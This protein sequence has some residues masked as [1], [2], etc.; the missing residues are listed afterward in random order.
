MTL[1]LSSRA[2]SEINQLI[3]NALQED[4]GRGNS[5]GD[6]TSLACIPRDTL[7]KA[8]LIIKDQGVLAGIEVAKLV[9]KSVDPTL[10][11]EILLE[12]GALVKSGDIALIVMGSAHSIL[13]AERLVLNIMQRMSGIATV[14]HQVV[15]S[16][17]GTSTRV[18][19]T[20]K[21]TPNCRILEKMAVQIGG[22]V[23]HRIGLYDMI[24]IKDNHVDYAGGIQNALLNTQQYLQDH[25][26]PLAIE[27][28][29][30]NLNELQ[31]VLDVSVRH[32]IALK[33]IM[34]DNFNLPTLKQAV[35]LIDKRYETEGSGGITFDNARDYACCG[36]DFISMGA[37]TH[38]VRSL[39]MSLK[40][41]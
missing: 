3:E 15:S 9:F 30:R 33:R 38:S 11:L 7:Q 24:L 1:K 32:N 23:N 2:V 36:V 25:E 21:T 12:E 35:K 41:F 18:L 37:L 14:T 17:E 34:L 29:V 5:R 22:G 27:I 16:L 4:L 8:R 19:D 13:I 40:A 10:C 20:R 39:D 31:Q 26:L 28:E 6:H